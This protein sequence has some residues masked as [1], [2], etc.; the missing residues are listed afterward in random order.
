M[1]L[2]NTGNGSK[3]CTRNAGGLK[4]NPSGVN[5]KYAGLGEYP[6]SVG[7]FRN[8]NIVCAG[9]LILPEVVITAA[10]CGKE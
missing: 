7:V 5:K 4:S 3:F 9:S 8:D 2:V 10:H 6:W 1:L